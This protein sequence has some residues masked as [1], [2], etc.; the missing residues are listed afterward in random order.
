[1]LLLIL[2]G[3]PIHQQATEKVTYKPHESTLW[4]NRAIATMTITRGKCTVSHKNHISP[5]LYCAWPALSI[6]CFPAKRCESHPCYFTTEPTQLTH[7]KQNT[8]NHGDL[9][10]SPLQWK[11]VTYHMSHAVFLQYC[12]ST[13]INNTSPKITLAYNSTCK[14]CL[15]NCN[16]IK[17]LDTCQLFLEKN[18]SSVK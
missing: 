17:E 10:R 12:E 14:R 8:E 13:C 1:M 4:Q 18:K 5:N 11:K 16:C 15:Y 2:D 3:C 9:N 7:H 6:V